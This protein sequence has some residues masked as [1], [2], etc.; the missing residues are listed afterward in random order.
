[1]PTEAE[2]KLSTEMQ[3]L[4]QD[5]GKLKG[6]L[7]EVLRIAGT[8]GKQK[9]KAAYDSTCEYSKEALEKTRKTIEEKP[10]MSVL[11]A[12]IAGVLLA[13]LLDRK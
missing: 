11:V 12:F 8:E 6:D 10:L 9:V 2:A 1:M 7:A 13:K 5:F 3:Q 4:K